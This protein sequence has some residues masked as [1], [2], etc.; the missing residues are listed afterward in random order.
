MNELHRA[1][2]IESRLGELLIVG[3]PGTEVTPEIESKLRAIAPAGVIFFAPNFPDA[4]TAGRLCRSLHGIL[5]TPERP[6][7]ISVD[8][9]G[10]MVSQLSGFWEVPPSARAVAASG[11]PPLVKDL[12]T[13]TA[14]RLLALGVNLNYAPVLDIHSN[15]RNPVIGIRSFGSSASQVTACGRAAIEGM[16]AVGMIPV[17]KHFPGH[18]D[19]SLDSHLTLP[20]LEVDA[21]TLALRELRPFEAAV[22]GGAPVVMV[23]HVSVPAVEPDPSVPATLSRAVVTGLLRERMGFQGVVVTDALE[24]AGATSRGSYGEVAVR[25][26]EAGCDLLLYSK[27]EPGPE[28]A[29]AAIREALRSGR[30]TP[31]RVALS[32]ERIGR[33]RA[34]SAARPPR[35]W[36]FLLEREAREAVP[37][38]ELERIAEGAL[39]ILRQ[40]AGGVPL[41]SPVDVLEI[42]RPSTRAPMADLLRAHG[43]TVRE[44]GEDPA[45]W[46]KRIEKS[47][48]LTIATRGEP[49]EEQTALGR[50]WLAR[51]PETVTVASLNPHAADDWPEVRT[52]FATFDNGPAS[53]RS[54]ARRLAGANVV[55]K[56]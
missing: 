49:T 9:E 44:H 51:F 45:G 36:S 41:H 31:E 24:M 28:E 43:M 50:A 22:N 25:A 29:L 19:T 12:A 15:P 6:A 37:G 35:D 26:I 13:R 32:I 39:R 10:G 7:L 54:L 42:N 4:G 11:G 2:E 33:L 55:V 53:R 52:L 56:K 48:L 46:P 23:A 38:D 17:V 14:Q 27:L 1:E 21:R 34:G 18:G 3:F 20:T 8:E 40:G 47:A 30:L 5:G 16:Q